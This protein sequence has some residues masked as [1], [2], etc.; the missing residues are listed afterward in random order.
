[1]ISVLSWKTL[2]EE[3]C[4]TDDVDRFA[5][6]SPPVEDPSFKADKS[7]EAWSPY[8]ET[9]YGSWVA[10]IFAVGSDLVYD[11]AKDDLEKL[12]SRPR[13]THLGVVFSMLNN[14]LP[15]Q[16]VTRYDYEF[17]YAFFCSV[18]SLRRRARTGDA[19][20]A[21]TVLEEL[22]IIVVIE[23]AED[24]L[25]SVG[26]DFGSIGGG[27]TVESLHAKICG[28][29]DLCI[30]LY[31]TLKGPVPPGHPYHFDC[32]LNQPLYCD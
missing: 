2:P 18:D 3:G 26:V 22:V 15:P 14:M 1:M 31:S 21:C 29:S 30:W 16:F 25:G 19:I 20:R 12:S 6:S 11:I 13:G 23:V 7:H 27:G 28:N 24:F 32:W 4:M 10:T 8:L 9:T 17:V 5:E